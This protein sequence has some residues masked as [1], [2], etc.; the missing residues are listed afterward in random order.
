MKTYS[1]MSNADYHALKDYISSSFVKSVAKH[2]IAKALQPIEPSQA[3]LFGD[4]MHTYFED[5][6]EFRKRFKVFKDSGIIAKILERRPDITSPTMTKDYKTYKKDFECSL[7]EN[8]V[9]ISEDDM[10]TI[11]YMYQSMVDN[12]A[13]KEI[14]KMY[15]SSESWDEY[16]F[17]TEEEDMHGL[18]YRVRP[19]RLLVRNEEP[20]AILDWKSCRDAS[21][22]SFR[23][24]F[25]KY[26][27][28]LQAAFYCDVMGILVDDFYFVAIEKQYPFNTAVYG[29]NPETQMNAL[30]ELNVI[31]YRI[32]EWKNNPKQ[33]EM[34]LPNTNTITL[35]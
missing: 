32:G 35:L 19:D 13:V 8:Q 22:K 18:K 15:D 12:D 1:N 34:G 27:Y 20:M 21:E 6:Q 30:K 16:S 17:L 25:W 11:Q 14:Y 23:S 2:S 7:G 9:A 5:S 26:R 3:L 4:A 29:L 31:K 24:D 28:D 33:A 10:Y